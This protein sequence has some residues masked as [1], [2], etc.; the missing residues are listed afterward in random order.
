MRLV[1][2]NLRLIFF[3]FFLSIYIL[4]NVPS[5]IFFIILIYFLT[6]KVCQEYNERFQ[7]RFATISRRRAPRR[8][9]RSRRVPLTVGLGAAGGGG[10]V[11]K[12]SERGR[13]PGLHPEIRF[14]RHKL[15]RFLYF[16]VSLKP[17]RCKEGGGGGVSLMGG[18]KAATP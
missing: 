15:P 16:K 1:S 3:C 4:V 10:R 9:P 8:S 2:N 12:R 5:R 17:R 14:K 7:P 11:L 6:I 18:C 13:L